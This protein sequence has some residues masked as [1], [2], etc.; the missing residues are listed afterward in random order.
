MRCAMPFT[1]GM[2][3]WI[4]SVA[5]IAGFLIMSLSHYSPNSSIGAMTAITVA[6]ALVTDFL[7]LPP[8]LMELDRSGP[9]APTESAP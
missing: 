4:T 5:L 6:L 9:M 1:V 8:L 7:L 2:A 3:L